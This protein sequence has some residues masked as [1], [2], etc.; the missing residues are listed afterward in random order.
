MAVLDHEYK[1]I[2]EPP[3]NESNVEQWDVATKAFLEQVATIPGELRA[4]ELETMTKVIKS[5]LDKSDV[6]DSKSALAMKLTG[7]QY[8][9]QD[10]IKLEITSLFRYFEKRKE[11]LQNSLTAAQVKALLGSKSR[12]TPHDRLEKNSLLAVRDNGICKFP[13]WQFDPSGPDGVI[14]GLPDVLKALDGS[15]FSK[16]N[17]LTS[18]NPYLDGL[19]PVESLKKGEK[20]RVL[21]EAKALGAL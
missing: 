20:E 15:E 16:L 8:S 7:R 2:A 12:Q 4:S 10:A 11:L 1:V 13:S 9:L 6:S 5:A 14:A 19:T 17:W 21:K 18:Q 3:A